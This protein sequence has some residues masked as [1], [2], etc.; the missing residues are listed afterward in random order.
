[1]SLKVAGPSADE[2]KA[3]PREYAIFA[4]AEPTG[5]VV[6][7]E[8]STCRL[9]AGALRADTCCN[10]LARDLSRARM[11][12]AKGHACNGHDDAWARME[13][14]WGGKAGGLW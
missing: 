2:V 8:V 5:D 14:Q 9:I 6:N 1:M 10:M 4:Q 3:A 7:K 12:L 13:A 11:L